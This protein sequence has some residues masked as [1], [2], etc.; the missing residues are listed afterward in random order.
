MLEKAPPMCAAKAGVGQVM[1]PLPHLKNETGD[2]TCPINTIPWKSATPCPLPTL[3]HCLW[4]LNSSRANRWRLL[5]GTR[6]LP[7]PNGFIVWCVRGF[8]LKKK[9]KRSPPILPFLPQGLTHSLN[10]QE[11]RYHRVF[12]RIFVF[13]Q[14]LCGPCVLYGDKVPG[15]L[16]RSLF[17]RLIGMSPTPGLNLR[18]VY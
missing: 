3:N 10:S 9:K 4:K 13:P 12:F 14:S 18:D 2:L 7:V 15:E 5:F 1:P 16:F 6:R 17:I 8:S 11:H